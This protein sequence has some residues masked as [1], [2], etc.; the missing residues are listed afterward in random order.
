MNDYDDLPRGDETGAMPEPG[1]EIVTN[2]TGAYLR[3]HREIEREGLT[4]VLMDI[5]LLPYTPQTAA[6]ELRELRLQHEELRIDRARLLR[7]RDDLERIIR[8]RDF[9]LAALDEQIAVA[10]ALLRARP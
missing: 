2:R 9:Q 8:E 10:E 1:I 4:Q 7:E 3:A 5:A 6:E